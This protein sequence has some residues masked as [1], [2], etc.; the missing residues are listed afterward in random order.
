MP[1]LQNLLGDFV[2]CSA[3]PHRAFGKPLVDG[4]LLIPDQASK[5][6]MRDVPDVNPMAD[7]GLL[8]V[9]VR[10]NLPGIPKRVRHFPCPSP[11]ED[12]LEI[13]L[14]GFLYDPL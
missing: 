2:R 4:L 8:D 12:S 6:D 9:Q 3:H 10:R 7:R 11:L 13:S 1:S 14:E 5:F